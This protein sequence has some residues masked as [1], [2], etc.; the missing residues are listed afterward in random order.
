MTGGFTAQMPAPAPAPMAAPPAAAP[1]PDMTT[2]GWKR[3]L[4]TVGGKS[5]RA[6]KWVAVETGKTAAATWG[7]TVRLASY[8]RNSLRHRSLRS[9]E[10]RAQL[11]LGERL[12]AAGGGD[13]QLRQQV[14]MID[15]QILAAE[16]TKASTKGLKAQRQD[17]LQKMGAAGLSQPMA[18]HGVETEFQQ[19]R[20]SHAQ[21]VKQTEELKTARAT[22]PPRDKGTMLRV[23]VGYAV[24]TCFMGLAVVWATGG[25]GGNKAPAPAPAPVG[26][27]KLKSDTSLSLVPADAAFYATTL[28]NREQIDAV[29][30]S[31]MWA[32]LTSTPAVQQA[33][34]KMETTGPLAEVFA[35]RKDAKNKELVDLIDEMWGEE[36]FVY[37]GESWTNMMRG[38][39]ER[40]SALYTTMVRLGLQ[41]KLGNGGDPDR[42]AAEIM[43][44]LSPELVVI[45]EVVVGF[46]LTRPEV[47]EPAL[48]R[49]EALLKPELDKVPQL[50]DRLKWEKV[51]DGN[52]LVLA[53]DGSKM[54]WEEWQPELKQP[55]MQGWLKK[56]KELKLSIS[57]GVRGKYLLMSIGPTTDLV[58]KLG[59]GQ[60]LADREEF[61]PLARHA[62]ERLTDINYVSRAFAGELTRTKADVARYGK[63]AKS[64]LPLLGLDADAKKRF[65][66]DIDDLVKDLQA[67]VPDPGA[68]LSYAFL[69]GRGVE[70]FAY[71]WTEN[72]SEDGS[73]PLTILNHVGGD[74]LMLSVGRSKYRPE[75]YATLVKWLKVGHEH[76]EKYGMASLT[77]DQRQAYGLVWATVKPQLQRLDRA[78]SDLLL[79]ALADSQAG[80]VLDAKLLVKEWPEFMPKPEQALPVPEPAIIMGV[81]NR[82]QLI[83][84]GTEYREVAN[85]LMQFYGNLMKQE[86]PKLGP[87]QMAPVNG[88]DLYFYPLPPFPGLDKRILPNAGLSSNVLAL[89]LSKEHSSRLLTPTPVQIDFLKRYADR[90]LAGAS[91]VNWAGTVD[92]AMQW[93]EHGIKSRP[94][95][96]APDPQAVD[97]DLKTARDIAQYFKVLRSM[98]SVTYVEG[99]ALVT[100]LEIVVQDLP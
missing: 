98:S 11:A 99:K 32:K 72:L 33:W 34:K 40:T 59:Q 49:I 91:H 95:F 1:M 80:W 85:D 28:R 23:G 22:L 14:A 24:S 5:A 19:A 13:P 62:E 67:Y 73:K 83:K 79:P 55:G 6:G 64:M 78:N 57:M 63:S 25:L 12:Y 20:E 31:K 84:A 96:A 61:A 69:N 17:F 52:F 47:A 16:A 66:K 30:K 68:T 88:G 2:P 9:R 7:Q 54:P 4:R 58:A 21:V 77:P 36:M 93:V 65:E 74:P 81:S 37:G 10:V 45:P 87:P 76:F 44:D 82:E 71:D 50:K 8:G 97:P 46:R 43:Q 53:V 56:Y 100:H 60:T 42:L 92:V 70:R 90:P 39:N 94:R 51:G 29:G 86:M 26:L 18:P 15:Q 89:S 35:W 38:W 75:K 41:G 3:A 48:K 27:A